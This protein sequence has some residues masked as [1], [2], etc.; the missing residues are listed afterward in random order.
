MIGDNLWSSTDAVLRGG[1]EPDKRNMKNNPPKPAS[2][3][4]HL[5]LM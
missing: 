1:Q 4:A 5:V 3:T 2:S